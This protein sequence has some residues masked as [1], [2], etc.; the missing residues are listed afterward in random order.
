MRKRKQQVYK[1][2]LIVAR[3]NKR[4][5]TSGEETCYLDPIPVDLVINILSRLPLEC[6]ARCR[7]VSKLWSSIVRRPNY[8]LLFPVKSPATPRLLFII[9]VAGELLFNSSHSPQSLNP[10]RNSS[11][12]ATSLQKTT[13]STN[14]FQLC[15]PVHGLVCR[16][17]I[18]EN[19]SSAVISNPITGEYLALPKLR[20]DEMNSETRNGKVRYS[21][22]YDPIDKQFKQVSK[23]NLIVAKYN[24]RS[25]TSGGETCYFDPIPVD[26]VINILSRLSLECIAGCRCVSKLWSSIIRRPNYNMLFPVKSTATPRLLFAFKVAEELLFNSSPQPHNPCRNLSLVATSLQRTSCA[27]FFQFCRPVHGLVCRQHIENNY[28]V[29][30]I[31]NPITGESFTLPKLRMEGMNS[32]RRNGK[33]RYSFGYDPIEKQFKVLRIAWLRSGSHERS[34]EYQVLTLGFG[35]HSWRKIQCRIVHYPLEDNG[36]CINGVLYYPAR[37][38][39]G[40]HTMVCFHIRSN[41]FS[42]TNIDLDM[43]T[44]ISEPLT[45]G[46]IDYKGKLGA[47]NCDIYHNVFDLWVL[48]DAKEKK[49]S[50]HIYEMPHPWPDE[51]SYVLSAGMIASGEIVLYPCYTR[52]PFFIYCYN[53]ESNIIRRVRLEVPVFEEFPYYRVYTFSNFVEALTQ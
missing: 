32:E 51:M 41:K 27:N 9:T 26:L 20:M 44:K 14:S 36:I 8:N 30:V 49:W 47:C 1:D 25:S 48:E 18:E 33:V 35:N 46:L 6:I 45:F 43:T 19:Y 52:G 7:C 4:S 22:G 23:D 38:S 34:S 24:K 5:S 12:V 2:N 29:G 15:R 53:L 13:C 3:S 17:H 37:L 39:T 10:N 50:K 40:R 31:S 28:S 11:L 16:H 21:F 42:F